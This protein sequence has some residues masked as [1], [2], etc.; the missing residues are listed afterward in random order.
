MA[1]QKETKQEARDEVEKIDHSAPFF[2]LVRQA[3]TRNI[4]TTV[5]GSTKEAD[6]G[7]SKAETLAQEDSI[8]FGVEVSVF[9]PQVAAFKPPEKPASV[10]IG[11]SWGD[12]AE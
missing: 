4:F 3:K 8:R 9:G 10:Q 11:F 5:I 7:R 2:V 6:L 1:D 12:K